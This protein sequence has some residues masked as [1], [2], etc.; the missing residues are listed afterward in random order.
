MKEK[1]N[2]GKSRRDIQKQKQDSQFNTQLTPRTILSC[3]IVFKNTTKSRWMN[4]LGK[5]V[6]TKLYAAAAKKKKK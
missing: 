6:N 2:K 1:S 5:E 4:T 3:K